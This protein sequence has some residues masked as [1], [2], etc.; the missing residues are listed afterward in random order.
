MFKLDSLSDVSNFYPLSLNDFFKSSSTSINFFITSISLLLLTFIFVEI[1][2][3]NNQSYIPI[4]ERI[5]K[6]TGKCKDK[7]V[8]GLEH[9]KST[10][11]RKESDLGL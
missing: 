3:N 7:Y 8:D 4:D 5:S 9:Q 6:G 2:Q 1:S 10:V 11:P